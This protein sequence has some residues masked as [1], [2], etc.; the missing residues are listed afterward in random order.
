MTGTF[1]SEPTFAAASSNAVVDDGGESHQTERPIETEDTSAAF[2]PH[3]ISLRSV[4]ERFGEENV[5]KEWTEEDCAGLLVQLLKN[6]C[7]YEGAKRIVRCFRE[8]SVDEINDCFSLC[9]ELNKRAANERVRMG[10]CVSCAPLPQ[11]SLPTF[12]NWSSVLAQAKKSR[13]I[14]DDSS[15]VVAK[16]LSEMSAKYNDA[17]FAPDSPNYKFIYAH[18]ASLVRGY[19]MRDARSIDAA[20]IL[21]IFE[22]MENVVTSMPKLL[23]FFNQ[24]IR[25]VQHFSN[26]EFKLSEELTDNNSGRLLTNLFELPD[27]FFTLSTFFHRNNNA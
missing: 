10:N 21:E 7:D 6:F 3:N 4:I 9:K 5:L 15:A 24:M 1:P 27:D 25:D 12:P 16:M 8:T 19:A 18:L 17:N 26:D 14:P 22:N 2:L 23:A 13:G 11:E 20:V